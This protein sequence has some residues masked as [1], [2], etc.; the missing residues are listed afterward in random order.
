M[1]PESIN[2]PE[3]NTQMRPCDIDFDNGLFLIRPQGIVNTAKIEWWD[4][5]TNKQRWKWKLSTQQ[6]DCDDNTIHIIGPSI[7]IPCLIK[8]QSIKSMRNWLK[9]IKSNDV[10]FNELIT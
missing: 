2:V 1:R 10:I 8:S 3:D 5:I 9:S 6:R 4:C 7:C